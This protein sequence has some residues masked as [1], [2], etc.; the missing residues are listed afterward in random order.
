MSKS[1]EDD[2]TEEKFPKSSHLLH[3]SGEENDRGGKW[4]GRTFGLSHSS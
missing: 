4:I 1:A 3:P 2:K